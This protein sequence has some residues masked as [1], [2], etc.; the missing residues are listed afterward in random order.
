MA[1]KGVFEET[2]RVR[3]F[4]SDNERYLSFVS[5]S[6]YILE[7]ANNHA[8]LL[9]LDIPTLLKRGLT[10][11]LARFHVQITRYPHAGEELTIQTWPSG[12]KKLFA[13][14]NFLFLSEQKEVVGRAYSAWLAIDL[15]SR[16]PVP[17]LPLVRD[18]IIGGDRDGDR[19]KKLDAVHGSCRKTSF[20]I[21]HSDTDINGHVNSVSYIRWI[22]DSLPVYL[23]ENRVI[24]FFDINY[25]GEAR[26]GEDVVC[27]TGGDEGNTDEYRLTL[28]HSVV[29]SDDT[30][31]FVR[32]VSCWKQ[33]S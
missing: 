13:L 27:K 1:E 32:A 30:K 18:I 8:R 29:D 15:V 4:E 26:Y 25:V 7:A 33:A 23:R 2:F 12:V 31:E 19:L 14:R 24:E 16:R 10:W 11:M 9:S 5:L 17:S 28:T 3:F 21:N 6:H 22:I 20:R